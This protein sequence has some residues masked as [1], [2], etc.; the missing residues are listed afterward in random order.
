VAFKTGCPVGAVM[1]DVT[2]RMDGS[3]VERELATRVAFELDTESDEIACEFVRVAKD[4]VGVEVGIGDEVVS[5]DDDVEVDELDDDVEVDELD[6]DVEV[7]E[8]DDD[9][10]VDELDDDQLRVDNGSGSTS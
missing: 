7:D 5:D 9:V 10:E 8:L 3:V 1:A 2:T 6:D 4:G